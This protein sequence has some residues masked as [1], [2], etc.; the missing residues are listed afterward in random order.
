MTPERRLLAI[1][2]DDH[3]AGAAAGSALARRV[4]RRYGDETGFEALVSV[5]HDIESDV[6]ALDDLRD[7]L[8]VH[9]GRAKR[10]VALAAERLGRLKPNGR[11]VRRS[12]L[13]RLVELE[14]LSAGVTAKRRLW[15]ALIAASSS[16]QL[17]DVD[18]RALRDRADNQLER[19]AHMHQLAAEA[20]PCPPE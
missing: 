7:R 6:R 19:I 13:S 8:G 20:I 12:P 14:L 2:L 4:E 18:L 16:Q 3:R 5:R 17:A 10:A 11:L 1:Y 15:D 9:G